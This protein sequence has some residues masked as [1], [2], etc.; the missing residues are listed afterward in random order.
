MASLLRFCSLSSVPSVNSTFTLA[1]QHPPPQA[2]NPNPD[3]LTAA[4]VSE[5]IYYRSDKV[6]GH[7]NTLS[8]N[9]LAVPPED[10]ANLRPEGLHSE[11]I[12]YAQNVTGMHRQGPAFFLLPVTLLHTPHLLCVHGQL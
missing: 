1:T 3:P 5:S 6:S 8:M 10:L 12:T 7:L 11:C 2:L 4:A 9:E